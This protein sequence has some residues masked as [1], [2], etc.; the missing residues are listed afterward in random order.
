[1]NEAQTSTPERREGK[2]YEAELL[3]GLLGA[4]VELY[5][6]AVEGGVEVSD[7]SEDYVTW[8]CV[9][10]TKRDPE[11]GKL[12]ADMF[13]AR[14]YQCQESF[15]VEAEEH[16]ELATQLRR[17]MNP[18]TPLPGAPSHPGESGEIPV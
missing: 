12:L 16:C 13:E 9:A 17:T 2:A 3:V 8:Y 1:M 10:V 18:P 4:V 14:S 7:V 15:P 11:M 6:A 5:E